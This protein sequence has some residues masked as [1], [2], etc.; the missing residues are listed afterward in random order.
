MFRTLFLS[1][2]LIFSQPAFAAEEKTVN[3]LE[4]LA[5][6]VADDGILMASRSDDFPFTARIAG[7]DT[8]KTYYADGQFWIGTK[9]YE[10]QNTVVPTSH[11][12][13]KDAKPGDDK[14][15]LSAHADWECKDHNKLTGQKLSAKPEFV[16]INGRTWAH[17]TYDLSAFTKKM[18]AQKPGEISGPGPKTQ[19]FVTTV[20]GKYIIVF[21]CTTMN[22]QEEAPTKDALLNVGKTF[23]VHPKGLSPEQVTELCKQPLP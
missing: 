9:D 18:K 11:F 20:L 5:A 21:I 6:Y 22:G 1:L 17:W 14:P 10:F 23:A 16:E 12:G 15:L 19:H 8:K 13:L 3:P 4:H 2:V 7:G